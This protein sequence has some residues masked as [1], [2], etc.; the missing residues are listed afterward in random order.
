MI[1]LFI[2][3]NLGVLALDN[4]AK[5]KNSIRTKVIIITFALLIII[6]SFTGLIN[7][8]AF[9]A[10]YNKSLI[11]T[12]SVVGNELV[13]KIEYALFYG[14]PIDNYYGKK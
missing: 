12:Y 5:Y 8:M 10:N 14:K 11:N 3:E 2:V 4:I 9:T 7:Y 13:R 1:T 6:M